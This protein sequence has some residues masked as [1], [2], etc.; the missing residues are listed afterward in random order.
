MPKK[1]FSKH[2]L[3]EGR[4]DRDFCA[5]LCRDLGLD[6]VQIG[7]PQDFGAGGNGKGNVIA[8]LPEMIERMKI[9]DITHLALM[10]D[11]DFAHTDGLGC[12]NTW[13]KIA[14][15]L[16]A[17]GYTLPENPPKNMQQ[18]LHYHYAGKLMPIGVWIMPGNGGDGFI[19]NFL[20]DNLQANEQT[21]LAH[22]KSTVATLSDKRFRP[23][24][25]SKAVLSTY[26]AWQKMPGQGMQGLHGAGVLDANASGMQSFCTW[27]KTCFS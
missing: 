5:A 16:R 3:V 19:E 12:K 8:L 21:L 15:T 1:V 17:N 10:V 22:A 18:G 11:A 20:M 9:G 13:R 6:D 24:H 2:L 26:A 25:E 23:H 27:L 14:D 7:P 4:A